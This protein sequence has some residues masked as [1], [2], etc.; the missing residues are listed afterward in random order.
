MGKK[1]RMVPSGKYTVWTGDMLLDRALH[2]IGFKREDLEHALAR[3]VEALDAVAPEKRIH[4]WRDGELVL[5]KREEGGAPDWPNRLRASENLFDLVGFKGKRERNSD[6][7]KPTAITITLAVPAP[8]A[9]PQL[10][11]GRLEVHLASNGHA[12]GNGHAD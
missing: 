2:D 1:R 10:P 7:G 6:T 11:A 12:D 8:D 4:E 5:T 3:N 9:G